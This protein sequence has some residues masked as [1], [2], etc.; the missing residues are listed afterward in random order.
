ME[1]KITKAKKIIRIVDKIKGT[2]F[3]T[4]ILLLGFL[5]LGEKMW[6]DSNWF[7]DAE[8]YI[9]IVLFFLI[10]AVLAAN[11]GKIFLVMYHNTLVRKS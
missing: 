7:I 3:L 2:F 1:E 9:Y 8:P 5:F 6:G 11:F 10:I 4:A